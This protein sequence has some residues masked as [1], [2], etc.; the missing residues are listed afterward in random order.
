MDSNLLQQ[1]R[2]IHIP[3]EAGWWPPA[4]GWWLLLVLALIALV[5]LLG[6]FRQWLRKRQPLKQART[7]YAEIYHNYRT[8]VISETHYLH[9]SNELLKRL[10]IHGLDKQ[11]ARKINDRSWLKFL[12]NLSGRNDFCEGP[13]HLLGNQR[14]REYPQ[15]DVEALH[16][17]I[18]RFFK[19]ARP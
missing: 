7:L 6:M 4:P 1:L 10:V 15:A 13:G 12:D 19:E 3:L 18:E 8:G 2:D 11:S 14:F 9:A 16:P 17:I 5:Y